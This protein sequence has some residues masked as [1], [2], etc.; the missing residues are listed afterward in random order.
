MEDKTLRNGYTTGSCA[1]AA[2]RAAAIEL[3]TGE[4]PTSVVISLPGG[5]T[6]GF[7]VERAGNSQICY[8]VQ[9][10]SGDDPDVTDKTYIYAS[11][12]FISQ[13]EMA[14]L[15]PDG[16]GYIM[17][18]EPR[19]YIDGGPGIGVVTREGLACPVGH[20]AINPAPRDEI[21][22]AVRDVCDETGCYGDLLISLAIPEGVSLAGRTFNPRLGI[23]G[24]ISVLGTS[25]VVRP[26]SEDAVLQTIKLELHMRAVAGDD[27]VIFTPGNYGETFLKERL[28]IPEGTAVQISNFVKDSALMACE[29]GFT[30]LLFAGHIG[31]LIKVAAGMPNTHSRYGDM[32]METLISLLDKVMGKGQ[33]PEGRIN[34]SG[35]EMTEEIRNALTTDEALG[36]ITKAFPA[37]AGHITADLLD[38]TAVA[39]KRQIEDWTDGHLRTEVIVFS[40]DGATGTT[41]AAKKYFHGKL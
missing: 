38:E 15:I 33:Y 2:A 19:I 25:G 22:A 23:S 32:R 30:G 9:K 40:R 6:A 37:D 12:R 24:G 13:E 29:E 1:S 4:S 10:D 26:M 28:G 8:R 18:G 35:S 14:R 21:A 5:G 16:R 7:S 27:K 34:R 17:E 11:C 3:L 31:K 39:V 41:V 20:Y 36:M